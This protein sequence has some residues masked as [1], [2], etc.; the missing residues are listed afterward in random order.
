MPSSPT[1]PPTA[2]E[3]GGGRPFPRL[4]PP[5]RPA[6]Q[7]CPSACPPGG[8]SLVSETWSPG[9]TALQHPHCRGG[10]GPGVAP[11]GPQ[12]R[13]HSLWGEGTLREEGSSQGRNSTAGLQEQCAEGFW[14][15]AGRHGGRGAPEGRAQR[16]GK[17]RAR[18]CGPPCETGLPGRAGATACFGAGGSHRRCRREVGTV[19]FLRMNLAVCGVEWGGAGEEEVR[20]AGG[21]PASGG[22]GLVREGGLPGRQQAGHGAGEGKPEALWLCCWVTAQASRRGGRAAGKVEG[23][24]RWGVGQAATAHGSVWM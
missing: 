10:Q 6:V 18:R 3:A 22:R 21:C 16:G 15:A 24:F 4:T 23:D 7:L 2:P 19:C 11:T 8:Q 5:S 1:R 12:R 20:G 17:A 9:H 14:K 13:C